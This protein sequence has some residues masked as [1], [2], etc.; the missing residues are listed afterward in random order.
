MQS[1][2]L[3]FWC[4]VRCQQV[5]AYMLHGIILYAMSVKLYENVA[6]CVCIVDPNRQYDSVQSSNEI[7]EIFVCC[8]H[9]DLPHD[10]IPSKTENV[11]W[12]NRQPFANKFSIYWEFEM[13]TKWN[14]QQFEIVII[15]MTTRCWAVIFHWDLCAFVEDTAQKI[16]YTNSTEYNKLLPM[17]SNKLNGMQKSATIIACTYKIF[18]LLP[19]LEDNKTKMRA[20]RLISI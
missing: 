4:C 5:Q 2:Q 17:N 12:K 16:N 6:V 13:K 9:N 8:T 1:S 19:Q 14:R 10:P 20:H 3:F 15:T 7:Y 18:L 11:R